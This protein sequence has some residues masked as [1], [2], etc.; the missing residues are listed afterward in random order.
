MCTSRASAHLFTSSAAGRRP[1]TDGHTRCA[2]L[3]WVHRRPGSTIVDYQ[4]HWSAG[5]ERPA[6]AAA[7]R[8]ER[9]QRAADVPGCW[10]GARSRPYDPKSTHHATWPGRRS[11]EDHHLDR[12][13]QPCLSTR[14]SMEGKKYG[15]SSIK[16]CERPAS[17]PSPNSG[18][19][20]GTLSSS[21]CSLFFLCNVPLPSRGL[22]HFCCCPFIFVFVAQ[23]PDEFVRSEVE[24]GSTASFLC[25]PVSPRG[26]PYGTCV[27]T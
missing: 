13:P 20:E 18:K 11:K 6:G 24:G 17:S 23:V 3:R 16:S 1:A 9:L 7:R 8:G 25:C 27:C 15:S 19:S 14:C 10:C 22:L 4:A 21:I 2:R 26:F 5:S 12:R